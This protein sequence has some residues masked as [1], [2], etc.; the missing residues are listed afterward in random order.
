LQERLDRFVTLAADHPNG[1]GATVKIEYNVTGG[2][3]RET[4]DYYSV[5]DDGK[6][7]DAK[8]G[9]IDGSD[10]SM[11]STYDDGQYPTWRARG[12]RHLHAGQDERGHGNMAKDE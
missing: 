10:F 4:S 8:R 6:I 12:R 11:T 2:P 5:I 1:P 3:P 7:L 9:T